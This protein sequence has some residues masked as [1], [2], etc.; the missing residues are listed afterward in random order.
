M[1]C[2]SVELI[3]LIEIFYLPIYTYEDTN[4]YFRMIVISVQ[5]FSW[6]TSSYIFLNDLQEINPVPVT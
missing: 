3:S 5:V 1:L 6:T 4:S 2:K